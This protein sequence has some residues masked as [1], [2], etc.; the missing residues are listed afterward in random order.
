[1]SD[2]PV[3]TGVV[4]PDAPPAAPSADPAPPAEPPP[5][6]P[7]VEEEGEVTVPVGVAKALREEIKSL[8]PLAQK[9]QQLESELN[10]IKPFATFLQQNPHLLQPH[11]PAPAPP[12]DP[13]TDPALIDYAR[14]LDLYT[15]EGQPDV[16]RA[17]KL[18]DMT[19]ADAQAIAREAL[20][21]IAASTNEQKAAANLNQVMQT[22][23]ANGTPLEEQYLIQAVQGVTGR[24]E[25]TE[26]VRILSDPN[27]VNLLA[28]TA[29]G[30]QS[31][32]KKGAPAPAAPVAQPGPVLEVERPGGPGQVQMSEDSRRLMRS[33]GVSEKQWTESAKKFVPG[34]SNVLE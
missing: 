13:K 5:A 8:K 3:L 31:M 10:A 24:V 32:Q 33:A 9:A 27:V 23:Q 30:L 18:R 34:K 15:A 21:P 16:A 26:A 28:I 2:E 1:M 22:A 7:V 4:D 6:D 14:T 29:L 11:Q 12:P 17:Q 20:A 19:R 25:R